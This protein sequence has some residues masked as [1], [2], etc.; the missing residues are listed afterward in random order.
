MFLSY[1]NVKYL[2]NLQY[3]TASNEDL[4]LVLLCTLLLCNI[5]SKSRINCQFIN[6][7]FNN[8]NDIYDNDNIMIHDKCEMIL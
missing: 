8:I 6:R 1:V 2:L 5:I 7:L 3:R 4:I